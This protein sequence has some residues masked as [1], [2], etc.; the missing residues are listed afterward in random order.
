MENSMGILVQRHAF[1]HN[2]M[3][4]IILVISFAVVVIVFLTAFYRG[5][6]EPELFQLPELSGIGTFSTIGTCGVG[7]QKCRSR[8]QKFF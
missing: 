8:T 7:T 6:L 4:K 1:G 2:K 5:T 3:K